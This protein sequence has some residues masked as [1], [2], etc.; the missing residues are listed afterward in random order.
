MG[1]KTHRCVLGTFHRVRTEPMPRTK[2]TR[3]YFT[4]D[5][6]PSDECLTL[7]ERAAEG[8]EGIVGVIKTFDDGTSFALVFATG[9]HTDVTAAL[10]VT[11][12]RKLCSGT[13]KHQRDS[14]V[15]NRTFVH[16]DPVRELVATYS[17]RYSSDDS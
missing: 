15:T 11:A 5:F 12:F 16:P 10:W 13:P 6:V 4:S 17:D 9:V 2:F 3:A 1:D 7:M 8:I 14:L